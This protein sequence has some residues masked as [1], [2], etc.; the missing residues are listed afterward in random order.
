MIVNKLNL[1]TK[2]T[3]K[4]NEDKIEL[5]KQLNEHK[6]ELEIHLNDHNN[7]IE[8]LSREQKQMNEKLRTE[9]TTFL[10]RK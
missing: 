5:Q 10:S 2:L 4:L 6:S 7:N 1:Q 8:T 3:E 9:F